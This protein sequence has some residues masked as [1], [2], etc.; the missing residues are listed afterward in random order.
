MGRLRKFIFGISDAETT[1]ARR[2]FAEGAASAR[3]RL[4]LIGRVFVGGYHAALL[5]DDPERLPARLGAVEPELRGFAFEGAAM[6][7]ALSDYFGLVKRDRW[8]RFLEGAG[9]DHQYMIYVGAGWAMAR[10]PGRRVEAF[11]EGSPL[12]R[13]LVVDGYGFHEGYFHWRRYRGGQRPSGLPDGYAPRVFDQGLGRSLWFV[14]CADVERLRRTVET[15]TAAR[16]ADLWS[17][18]GLACGYAGG[19]RREQVE[20]LRDAVGDH[21]PSLGQGVA[22]AAKTRLRAGNM[23]PHT[24]L[25]CETLCGMSAAEAAALTD[26]ALEGLPADGALPS[27]EVWRQRIQARFKAGVRAR[28]AGALHQAGAHAPQTT[29]VGRY[30]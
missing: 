17:G 4:E 28:A 6:A 1:F 24:E 30:S 23:A 22:F 19:A 10:L 26:E 8:R 11:G 20:R 14:K 12:L 18:I 9:R 25:A 21:L 27:F 16:R 7:L 3:S 15:F 29:E 13:W 5:D 2:G